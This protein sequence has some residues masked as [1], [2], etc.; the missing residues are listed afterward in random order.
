MALAGSFLAYGYLANWHLL[1]ANHWIVPG[2]EWLFYFYTI[3][4]WVMGPIAFLMAV[5][6]FR[7]GHRSRISELS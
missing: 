2:A 5:A 4:G 6:R 7:E 1:D 3:F